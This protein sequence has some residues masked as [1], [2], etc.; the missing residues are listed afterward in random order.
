MQT[1]P[2]N[3]SRSRTCYSAENAA[4]ILGMRVD[5]TDYRHASGIVRGWAE[6]EV[7]KYVCVAPVSS[8]MEAYDSQDF[9]RV[10]SGADLVTPD[11]MPVVWGLRLLG[12]KAASRVY[13]P[14]L[15]LE[16]LGMAESNNLPIGF[17]GGTPSVL[18]QLQQRITARFP[19]LHIAYAYSPPFRSLTL[20]EGQQVVEA[21][22]QA[23]VRILFVGI[24]SPKQE[25]WMAAQ[26]GRIRAVMIG[27][28]AAFDFLSGTKPQAPR[29]IMKIGMEWLFRL[30]TEPRRLWKRYLKHNP[31][32]VVLFAA[33]LLGLKNFSS[34]VTDSTEL[35]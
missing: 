3:T 13:G 21:I 29:W 17:Y 10:I 18:Q 35:R 23:D 16:V 20:E 32:F 34:S 8:V 4:H 28:G 11:G 30:M 31:R 7:S 27:V 12:F 1:G 26:K 15:T 24:G 6:R 19:N 25:H 9:Q 22:N 14:D 2:R 5:A 33:Q